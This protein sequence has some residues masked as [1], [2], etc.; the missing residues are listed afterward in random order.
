MSK[1]NSNSSIKGNVEFAIEGAVFNNEDLGKYIA[2]R[3]YFP[4]ERYQELFAGDVS[5]WILECVGKK[6]LVTKMQSE[7]ARIRNLW[8][9]LH[10]SNH[11]GYYYCHIGGEWVHESETELDHI[12]PSSVERINTEVPGWDNKLRMACVPH[13]FQKGSSRVKSATMEVAPLDEEC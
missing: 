6:V 9:K 4:S 1:Q 5:N 7:K 10:P 12:V 8:K 13:N 3:M 11:A 2:G